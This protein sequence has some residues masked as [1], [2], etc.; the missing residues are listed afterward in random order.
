MA[1]RLASDKAKSAVPRDRGLALFAAVW[2]IAVISILAAGVT[3][4][5]RTAT[6]IVANGAIA[7]HRMAA[8]EAGLAWLQAALAVQARGVTVPRDGGVQGTLALDGTPARWEFAG[9][10]VDLQARL[11]IGKIDIRTARPEILRHVLTQLAGR[12]GAALADKILALRR[13]GPGDGSVSWR[14]D[15]HELASVEDLRA[16]PRMTPERFADLAPLLTVRTQAAAPDLV[17]APQRLFRAMLLSDDERAVLSAA[18]ATRAAWP[19]GARLVR[20]TATAR[21]PGAPAYR[22]SALVLIDPRGNPGVTLIQEWMAAAVV[23][24]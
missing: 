5:S 18:R 12:D 24:N 10:A 6:R 11:E 8:A 3:Q 13:I 21:G 16:L 4:E 14:I 23:A 17:W 9:T 22:S 1:D 2:L 19:G 20:L 7:A 15:H